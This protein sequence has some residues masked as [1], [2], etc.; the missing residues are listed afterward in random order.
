MNKLLDTIISFE[1]LEEVKKI[2]ISCFER[3]FAT[4]STESTQI[5]TSIALFNYF[6]SLDYEK[7]NFNHFEVFLKKILE[8][9]DHTFQARQG[10]LIVTSDPDDNPFYIVVSDKFVHHTII[11]AWLFYE[12]ENTDDTN[13]LTPQYS[14]VID[15]LL[16]IMEYYSQEL[17]KKLD[18]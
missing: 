7:E 8:K 6:N 3:I 12:E 11:M 16:N 1:Y 2:P 10:N 4:A 14:S 15:T 5:R 13:N 18:E 9:I 17:E